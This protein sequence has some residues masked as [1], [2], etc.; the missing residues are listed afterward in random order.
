LRSQDPAH[1]SGAD[2]SNRVKK[3][4]N[5]R[6]S[7]EN[8][9]SASACYLFCLADSSRLPAIEGTGVDGRSPLFLRKA[10]DIVAV[11]SPV[12]LEEFCGPAAE[13]K[14][15]DL[16]W[17]GPRACRHEEIVEQAMGRSPVLPARFGT[18]FSSL[19]KLETLISEHHG[20]ISKFLARVADKEEWA[21]K[22]FLDRQRAHSRIVAK[23]LEEQNAAP[24]TVTPG[25][26]YFQEQRIR[27][28]AEKQ[29]ND[30]VR[31]TCSEI[32][33]ELYRHAS[34]FSQGKLISGGETT[35]GADK[36]L[37]WAFLVPR[38]GAT[39][40]RAQIDRVNVELKS[41]GLAFESSGPWPPYSFCPSLAAEPV[42]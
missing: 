15:K 1:I 8:Q 4:M 34:D 24:S 31:K 25:I 19:E 33:G 37:N 9:K 27:A 7:E 30:W 39:G 12:A 14:M 40:F 2:L 17:M 18:I 6:D 28:E 26:R 20:A 42:Q 23:A 36:I 10:L 5:Q 41:H 21:V 38:G 32:A 16:A 35:T 13:Q 29:L 22:G 11:L 3:S